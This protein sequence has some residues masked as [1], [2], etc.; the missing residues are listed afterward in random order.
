M[1]A[2]SLAVLGDL[3]ASR[4]ASD[5]AAL[6]QRLVEVL[7]A[8]NEQVP[9]LDPLTPTVGD[10]FQGRYGGLAAG[11][12][13]TLLVRLSL[14]PRVDVRFGLGWGRLLVHDPARAP[15]GQEGPAW[16]SARDALEAVAA[17][18]DARGTPPGWRTCLRVTPV[19]DA[20]PRTDRSEPARWEQPEEKPVVASSPTPPEAVVNAHLVC[21]DTL[22]ARMDARDLRLTRGLLQGRSQ[23]ELAAAEGIS[24]SAVSQRVRRGGALAVV[25]ADAILAAWGGNDAGGPADLQAGRP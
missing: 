6:Q 7:A 15:F 13:A 2:S 20:A 8:V 24:P 18:E 11:V 14:L 4:R 9:P 1:A 25:H 5:R 12:R 22:I 19:D 23:R 10:E 21:R 3:V 16:W 17:A